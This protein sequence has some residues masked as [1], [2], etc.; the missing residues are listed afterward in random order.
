MKKSQAQKRNFA[1]TNSFKCFENIIGCYWVVERELSELSR[2][3]SLKL[4]A[5][6]EQ[7]HDRGHPSNL[8]SAVWLDD[9]QQYLSA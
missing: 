1:I 9:L 7:Y 4:L 6:K 5:A 2:L 8:L 3:L